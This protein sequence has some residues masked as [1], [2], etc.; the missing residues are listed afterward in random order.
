MTAAFATAHNL[1]SIADLKPIESQVTIGAAR[2][3]SPTRQ[4]G[5]LGLKKLYGLTLKFKPLDESGPLD[6]RR[7]Q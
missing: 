2:R 6:H 7:P 4:E 5:L 3:S 1:K